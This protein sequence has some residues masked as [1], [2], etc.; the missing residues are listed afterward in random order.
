VYSADF[1]SPGG[2]ACSRIILDQLR[3]YEERRSEEEP[4]SLPWL[5]RDVI[6][7]SGA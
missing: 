3:Y 7:E 6:D 2:E 4:R 1:E 5:I